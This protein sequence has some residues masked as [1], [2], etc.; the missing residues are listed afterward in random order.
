MFFWD[1]KGKQT[2]SHAEDLSLGVQQTQPPQAV[3][4]S[5]AEY[6]SKRQYGKSTIKN[7]CNIVGLFLK[8]L[9]T[10]EKHVD[11]FETQLKFYLD[12]LKQSGQC[13][14]S[15]Y[16]LQV[17]ALK[18][19]CE[20]FTELSI[21]N[22]VWSRPKR[23]QNLPSVLSQ[24]DIKQ[25][26]EAADNTKSRAILA[27]LYAT[28]MKPKELQALQMKHLEL[29][30]GQYR[31]KIMQENA[32]ARYSLISDH[33]TKL[34]K[35]YLDDYNPEKYLF[36]GK[37][38]GIAISLRS[39]EDIF[40]RSLQAANLDNIYNVYCLRHSFAVH[41]IEQGASVQVLSALMGHQDIRTTQQYNH[42]AK[43]VHRP[44][45]N[46]IDSIGL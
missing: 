37:Q 21:C 18:L 27:V 9:T 44:S 4:S 2:V 40:K 1:N 15:Y 23:D 24:Q 42:I 10:V 33:L 16:N 29:Q 41:L 14:S 45:Q 6:L 36:E 39:V 32:S 34:L 8:K 19:F 46:P 12:A 28:G 5:F 38:A 43:Y 3:L 25:L 30:Q 17:N 35:A 20:Q 13:R 26:L 22:S 31:I 11:C 7:Y